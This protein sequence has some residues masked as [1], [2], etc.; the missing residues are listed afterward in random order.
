VFRAVLTYGESS[1]RAYTGCFPCASVK[2]CMRTAVRFPKQ[3]F[4]IKNTG[5]L[6]NKAIRI[7]IIRLHCI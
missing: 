5:N 6:T 1:V 7:I 2:E 3:H 4:S